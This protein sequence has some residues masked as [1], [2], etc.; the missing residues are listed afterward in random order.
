ML[1]PASFAKNPRTTATL[2]A[3]F[4]LLPIHL[5]R[6]I[7]TIQF[8]QKL[9]VQKYYMLWLNLLLTIS[10]G[11]EVMVV[12]LSRRKWWCYIW[13]FTISLLVGAVIGYFFKITPNWIV[14]FCSISIHH[15]INDLFRNLFAFQEEIKRNHANSQKQQIIP[16]RRFFVIWEFLSTENLDSFDLAYQVFDT[17]HFFFIKKHQRV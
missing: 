13:K 4:G 3:F 11:E 9:W 5:S 2:A 17:Q 14:K 15:W 10:I 12:H 1:N 7:L 6:I 8:I 16:P